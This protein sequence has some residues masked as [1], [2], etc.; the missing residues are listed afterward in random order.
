VT[1]L[2]SPAGVAVGEVS[3]E[4]ARRPGGWGHQLAIGVI[5]VPDGT[6]V[7]LNAGKPGTA[8]RGSLTTFSQANR[9][10]PDP[11]GLPGYQADPDPRLQITRTDPTSLI[12]LPIKRLFPPRARRSPK[13]MTAPNNLYGADSA[14]AVFSL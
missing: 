10:A 2:Q 9:T 7:Q 11:G 1:A 14:V 13:L 3:W 4:D 12:D 5:N 8:E 6:A